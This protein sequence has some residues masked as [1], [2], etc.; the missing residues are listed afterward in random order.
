MLDVHYNTIRAHSTGSYDLLYID[1][2]T[3]VHHTKHKSL[4]TWLF[5]NE[6]GIRSI[7]YDGQTCK[8]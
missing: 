6:K 5:E 3:L 7:E 1:T 4:N 2:D 8:R